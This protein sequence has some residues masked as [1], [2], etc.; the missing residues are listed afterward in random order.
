MIKNIVALIVNDLAISFKNKS[1]FLILFVPLFVVITLKLADRSDLPF[2]RIKIG[3][4]SNEIYSSDILK[5]LAAADKVFEVSR[6]SIEDGRQRLKDRRLDGVLV[7]S[8][9]EPGRLTLEVLRRE[10]L[11]AA[12]IVEGLS[13]LQN[14]AAGM[15]NRWLADIQPLQKGGAQ[16]QTLPA[17]VLMVVLL[18]GL[19]IIPAQVA[20]EK[21][22]NLLL[23]LLQTPMR[24]TEWL[25]AK[26]LTGI[27]LINIAV[28]ILHI[29]TGFDPIK[30][31][32]Y[33]F[34]LEAGSFCFSSFGI[35]LGFLCK[36]QAS[37]RTLGVMVYIL[38]LVPSALSD[39]S[40]KLSALACYVPS[41]QLYNPL[42]SILLENS[43]FSG[44]FWSWILLLL[45]GAASFMFSLTL[46]KRRWLM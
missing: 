41:Y 35:L 33:I 15:Q 46:M 1:I 32:G 37:A 11:Q 8:S 7:N 39:V 5:S 22:K 40:L 36:T 43:A 44:F 4:I 16:K 38:F 26:L 9:K 13:V 34:F 10:S 14:K 3:L 27:I 12:S 20:E 42:R 17:W 19:I 21:E 28:L 30:D 18:A 25:L 23:G 6:V 31:P 2:Q 45:L 24:E 29:P